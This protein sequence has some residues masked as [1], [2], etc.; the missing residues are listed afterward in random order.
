MRK[1]LYDMKII[2]MQVVGLRYKK[3]GVGVITGFRGDRVVV[4]Y[5]NGWVEIPLKEVRFVY[6]KIQWVD[7]KTKKVV[8]EEKD[9]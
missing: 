2:N 9:N 3:Y 7:K 4:S 5:G 1:R 6:K 8:L